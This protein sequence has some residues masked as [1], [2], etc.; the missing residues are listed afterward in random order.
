MLI[1]KFKRYQSGLM[2]EAIYPKLVSICS[3][4]CGSPLSGRRTR[5]AS[6]QCEIAAITRF[7]IIKGDAQCIREELYKR[8]KGKC[9]DCGKTTPDWDADHILEVSN[10]GGGCEL[11]NFQTLCKECHKKKTKNR[12]KL[13]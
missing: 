1:N 8:D 11:D 2:V 9:A 4:G 12:T 7:R 13:K 6:A 5:W 3:C 10:G